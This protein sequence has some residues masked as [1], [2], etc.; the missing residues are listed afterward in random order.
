M[1]VWVLAGCVDSFPRFQ[2]GS[3]ALPDMSADGTPGDAT[4]DARLDPPGDVGLDAAGDTGPACRPETCDGSDEDCDGRIDEGA[5]RPCWPFDPRLRGQGRCMDGHESC[6]N[7]RWAGDCTAAIGPVDELCNG[8]DED[9]DGVADPV[10]RPC[11]EGP[12]GTADV[13]RC[14]SGLERCTGGVWTGL[15]EGTVGPAEESCDTTD[16][17]CDGRPDEALVDCNPDPDGDEIFDGDNC[18]L[19]ANADQLDTDADGVGNACD[20]DDD[21]DGMADLDDCQPL[22]STAF[23]GADERC[24]GLDQDC[25][26]QVDEALVQPC[27]GGEE[28][29]EGVGVCVSGQARCEAGVFGACVGALAP[30]IETCDG[31]DE[32]CDGAIDEGLEPGWPDVDRDGF[33][34]AR[35]APSCPALPGQASQG[36]D[37]NDLDADVNPGAEDRLGLGGQ[38][39]DCDGVDGDRDRLVFVSPDGD[40]SSADGSPERPFATLPRAI[41]HA[42]EVPDLQGVIV[43]SGRHAG[44]VRLAP[45]V[46][47]YGGF[48]R[49]SGWR[50]GG[51]SEIR[52]EGAAEDLIAVYAEDVAVPT[53][54]VDLTLTTADNPVPGG[55]TY[56]LLAV[57]SSGLRLENL[58]VTA[59]AGGSGRPGFAGA[60]G[61]PGGDGGRGGDCGGDP[62]AGGPSV[63]APGG[64]GGRGARGDNRGDPGLPPGCGGSG[65]AGAGTFTGGDGAD[66]CTP[67]GP[68]VSGVS[69]APGFSGAV[70]DGRWRP[71]RGSDGSP[72]VN[73]QPGGGG[74]GGGGAGWIDRRAGA[75][76]GGGGA[77]CAGGRGTGGTA[78]GG[79][80]GIFAVASTGL[81]ITGGRASAGPG[82]AGGAG[83]PGGPG[84]PGGRGGQRGSGRDWFAC[85]GI[86]GPGWGGNGGPGSAGSPG[87]PGAG[88]DGGTTSALWCVQTELAPEDLELIPGPG[89]APGAGPGLLGAPGRSFLDFGCDGEDDEN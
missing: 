22:D 21:D 10:G 78:G 27:Y 87:G 31:R 75:G 37:C 88:G 11:Y 54:L 9:C 47:L 72:G 85:G 44:P 61:T 86:G 68:D 13:G 62:G 12:D 29:T 24:D 6:A 2:Q 71:G 14:T 83:G 30:A 52:A 73:G 16:E 63:C 48:D 32:D 7:G 66:G 89:G 18:P 84:G 59:G 50:R 74:G 82:G 39:V 80:F 28:G 3:D 81:T 49:A 26:G 40:D 56:G 41:T 46:H 8:V 25:D 19:I 64:D 42:T 20:P 1:W 58:V 23:P 43:G 51:T 60:P 57:R 70:I 65:G 17:D 55:N 53:F 4:Q 34:D 15:C 36:N 35:A 33:G 5:F 79:S 69:G 76:G 45:G 67:S 38:D 77:G